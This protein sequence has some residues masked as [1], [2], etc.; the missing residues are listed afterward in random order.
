MRRIIAI[1]ALMVSLIII[2][3]GCGNNP[4]SSTSSTSSTETKSVM[5]FKNQDFWGGTPNQPTGWP[6]LEMVLVGSFVAISNYDMAVTKV[7]VADPGPLSLM[8][9][10]FKDLFLGSNRDYSRP[11]TVQEQLNT[12][13]TGSSAGR[14]TFVQ[15][16]QKVMAGQLYTGY[17]Y[18]SIRSDVAQMGNVRGIK[19]Y[20]ITV[21][22]GVSSKEYIISLDLQPIYI[23]YPP[24]PTTNSGEKG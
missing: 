7:T 14:Y 15:G 13:S 4:A 8:G 16:S 22:D 6:G 3:V 24:T 10:N 19:L 21:T 18:A 1:I 23:G 17:V 20:S 5:I 9:D 12:S 2:L 11:T